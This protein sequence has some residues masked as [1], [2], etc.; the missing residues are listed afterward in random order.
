MAGMDSLYLEAVVTELQQLLPGSR[1]SKI[2]QPAASEVIFKLWG[3]GQ[4]RRLLLS[5]E[6][7]RSR[8]HLVEGTYPNP[9]APP[10]F[11]QLLR[12]R[13]GALTGIEQ[14]PGERIVQLSFSGEN[15]ACYRLMAE[16][17]GRTANLILVDQ[18]GLVVDALKRIPA[19]AGRGAVLPGALYEPLQ[20][21]A[22][23]LLDEGVPELPAHADDPGCLENWL[24]KSVR[25]MSRL[26]ARELAAQVAAGQEPRRVVEDFIARR[27]S[28]EYHF[29]IVTLDNRPLL[30]PI[31]L[32]AL[33]AAELDHFSSPSAAAEAY[34]SRHSTGSDQHGPEG[35]MRTMVARTMKKLLRRR[36]RILADQQAVQQ[37]DEFRQRGELLLAQLYRVQSGEKSVEL[38]NYYLQP[39]QPVTIELDPRLSPQQNAEKYFRVYKKLK[40]SQEHIVRRLAETEEEISWLEG[41]ALALTEARQAD[42]FLAVRRELLE[43]GMLKD[44][45]S[46]PLPRPGSGPAGVREA[47]SPNGFRICWGVNNRANDYVSKKLCGADD[48]WFHAHEL[49]GCHLVLKRSERREVPEEDRLFAA[50]LAAGYSRGRN[51]GTVTVMITEGRWVVKPKG[52][53]PGLVTVR[54]YQTLRVAPRREDGKGESLG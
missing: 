46:Q 49:P 9:S 36:E 41:V 12:A 31:V 10:R 27:R 24:C 14:L 29:A 50:S 11:C 39:P 52:A 44:I 17:T 4:T 2:F 37:A 38:D 23:N 5:C 45:K 34:F 8:L 21:P 28:G 26:V 40:R 6:A 16:L 13:L 30:T 19:E 33:A 51:D 18:Q 20:P 47:V 48:L 1:I 35:E 54:R 22:T 25:P 7:G 53:R 15:N 3:R 32:Q 43:H 42:E